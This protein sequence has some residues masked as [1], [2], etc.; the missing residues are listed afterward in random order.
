MIAFL[1]IMIAFLYILFF[2][3]ITCLYCRGRVDQVE[4]NQ[5]K[6]GRVRA[7][8]TIRKKL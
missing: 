2:K 7:K 4:E 1:Y 5:V 8:K 6:R 3:K